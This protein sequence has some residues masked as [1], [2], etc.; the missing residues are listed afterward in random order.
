M[1]LRIVFPARL[2]DADQ[3]T[4]LPVVHDEKGHIVANG[5]LAQSNDRI[6]HLRQPRYPVGGVQNPVVE[7]QHLVPYG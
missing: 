4:A 2:C 3:V 6:D 5:F 1:P 7:R